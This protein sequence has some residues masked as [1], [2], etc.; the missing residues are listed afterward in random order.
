[1]AVIDTSGSVGQTELEEINGEL[2][3]MAKDFEVTVVECDYRIHDVYPYRDIT[4]IKGRGGTSFFPPFDAEF[5][6]KH[7]PDVIVYFTDG[8]GEAPGESP[9]IPVYWC[10]SSGGIAPTDWG[11]RIDM[12]KSEIN[13]EIL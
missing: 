11:F 6:R 5:L 1:M 9:K 10:I 13:R 12:D 8:Y 7:R 3:V 4:G 2:R